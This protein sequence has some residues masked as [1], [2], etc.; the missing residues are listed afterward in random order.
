MT[1]I[2]PETPAKGVYKNNDFGDCVFYTVAC[3]C[4]NADHFHDL[5]VEVEADDG[6]VS[7]NINAWVSTG[8]KYRLLNNHGFFTNI[9]NGAYSRIRNIFD[10]LWYGKIE[11]EANIIMDEQSAIN[12]AN[13][14]KQ[15][16]ENVKQFKQA[17]LKK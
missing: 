8:Y 12:Y 3:D 1:Q 10:I 13:I 16:T 6:V 11:H 4:G 17:R 15:A 5:T 9:V 14:L 2:K 7:V